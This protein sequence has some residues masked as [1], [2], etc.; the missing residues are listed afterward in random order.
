MIIVLGSEGRRVGMNSEKKIYRIVNTIAEDVN[1]Q[2]YKATLILTTSKQVGFSV[3]CE[4]CKN[5]E[6]LIA[7]VQDKYGGGI[8][9]L[10]T[11]CKNTAVV[12]ALNE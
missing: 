3:R 2:K 11:I 5:W 6:I 4:S 1:I 9:F 7:P 8:R 10:C 12:G